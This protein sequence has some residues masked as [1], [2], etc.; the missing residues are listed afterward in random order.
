MKT[1]VLERTSA[2]KA[3][4]LVAALTLGWLG[5]LFWPAPVEEKG[6]P[7]LT[8]PL[9]ATSLTRAGLAEYSDW[10]GLPEIFALWADRADWKDDRTR[11]AYW[12]PA[13]KDHSYYFEA[14]RTE[15]GYRFREIPEPDD[16]DYEWDPGATEDSPLL[17]FLPKQPE[18]VLGP[19][20]RTDRGVLVHPA[21]KKVE[22]DL[23]APP[24]VP[25]PPA[26]PR[27]T[28]E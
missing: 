26:T 27:K 24:P 17:L 14:I 11:F 7:P 18:R 25:V 19:A 12:H 6:P 1:P 2:A 4:W 15:D 22:I 13:M 23:S 28:E 3:G 8:T 9:P 16:A 10:V 5:F 21:P 20:T